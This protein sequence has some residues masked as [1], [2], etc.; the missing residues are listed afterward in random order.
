MLD[1]GYFTAKATSASTTL[2]VVPTRDSELLIAYHVLIRLREG[3][4]APAAG[5]ALQEQLL[6][7]ED[8]LRRD[9][10]R[11]KR[12]TA[13]VIGAGRRNLK[14][15]IEHDSYRTRNVQKLFLLASLVGKATTIAATPRE[16]MLMD[17]D[18][19]EKAYATHLTKEPTSLALNTT[20]TALR[21]EKEQEAMKG[22]VGSFL[23]TS[24]QGSV[25]SLDEGVIATHPALP[26][27][28]RLSTHFVRP[29]PPPPSGADTASSTT[30]R[31]L[32]FT[33]GDFPMLL[34][35]I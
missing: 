1:D 20:L 29:V 30:S 25:V 28:R 2:G 5:P 22:G 9:A 12:D 35:P 19:M 16:W 26:D 21:D 6:I 27:A 11:R 31:Q 18:V 15:A 4:K 7:L 24:V 32:T 17:V 23:R 8:Q 10:I 34:L 13:I 3:G 33:A 14:D